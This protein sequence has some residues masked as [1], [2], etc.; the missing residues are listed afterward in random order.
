[1]LSRDDWAIFT[2]MTDATT[3]IVLISLKTM[4]VI[5]NSFFLVA[6]IRNI[7]PCARCGFFSTY[8]RSSHIRFQ[9]HFKKSKIV[10]LPFFVFPILL[11]RLTN[12]RQ[13]VTRIEYLTCGSHMSM[14][15]SQLAT[16]LIWMWKLAKCD[17][18]VQLC[19]ARLCWCVCVCEYYG[20]Y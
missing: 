4:K 7:F 11:K 19:N 13:S 3:S 6:S 14:V 18:N 9:C 12:Q 20:Q 16:H 8:F 15:D 17:Q 2:R 5:R 10:L 1:M